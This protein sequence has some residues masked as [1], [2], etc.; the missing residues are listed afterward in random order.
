LT[1]L[2]QGDFSVNRLQTDGI[3]SNKGT[4]EQILDV[5]LDEFP[6]GM[7]NEAVRLAFEH[8]NRT[9]ER[10][11]HIKVHDAITHDTSDGKRN[12]PEGVT[13]ATIYLVRDPRDVALS[14]ANHNGKEV[15][16]VTRRLLCNPQGALVKNDQGNSQFKQPLMSW[17]EHFASWLREPD[18]NVLVIRYEDMVSN[19][20]AAFSAALRHMGMDRSEDDIRRAIALTAFDRLQQKE[21]EE[22]FRAKASG[23][24]LFFHVGKTGRWREELSPELASLI[25]EVNGEVMRQLGYL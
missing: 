10:V 16:Q 3:F 21:K 13:R 5:D 8:R 19:P 14:L 2:A 7:L 9:A 4:I 25:E 17:A 6:S 23:K 15:E 18:L 24:R 11:L 12:I 20:L 1:A 22:G